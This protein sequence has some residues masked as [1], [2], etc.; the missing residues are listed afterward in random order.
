MSKLIEEAE[1]YLKESAGVS[2]YGDRHI[3]SLL[4]H[5]KQQDEDIKILVDSLDVIEREVSSAYFKKEP[6][7]IYSGILE[8]ARNIVSKHL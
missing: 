6:V 4:T 1:I 2:M 3:K 8:E 7:L 5:I